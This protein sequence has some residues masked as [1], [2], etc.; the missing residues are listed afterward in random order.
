M[1]PEL[2]YIIPT[3]DREYNGFSYNG[4]SIMK[5]LSGMNFKDITD[6]SK[7]DIMPPWEV[8]QH[9]IY[10]KYI[11]LETLVESKNLP[12]LPFKKEDLPPMPENPTEEMWSRLLLFGN[13]IHEKLMNKL[14][15]ANLEKLK[16]KI[17][18]WNC[19]VEDVV[20]WLPAHDAYHN[21][22]IRNS[23]FDVPEPK[24]E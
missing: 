20:A 6:N 11:V 10:C 1:L 24:W 13:D 16:T 21:A 12:D 14:R 17:D 19:S 8:Y 2:K 9:V 18:L 15:E 22:Q 23:G 7:K 4:T 3:M 5:T